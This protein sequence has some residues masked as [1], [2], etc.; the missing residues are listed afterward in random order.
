MEVENKCTLYYFLINEITRRVSMTSQVA[1]QSD[2]DYF[3]KLLDE[4]DAAEFLGYTK[5]AMQNWR[6]RGGGPPFIRVSA[7]SIRY[8]RSDLIEW[9]N[10]K[11]TNNTS[12][13]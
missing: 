8:R 5:R 9:I 12:Q 6:F 7:R 4:V 11:V 1:T 3:N 13:Y 2:A 10:S